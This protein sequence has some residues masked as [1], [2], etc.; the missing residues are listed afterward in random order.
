MASSTDALSHLRCVLH[1]RIRP[2]TLLEC[3]SDGAHIICEE[4]YRRR[5]DPKAKAC[6]EC[7]DAFPKK[8]KRARLAENF[9]ADLRMGWNCE[10]TT[11][12]C[13]FVVNDTDLCVG[14]VI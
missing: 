6:P 9:I 7:G 12:G 3:G 13:D 8:P 10:N 1:K 2:S 14:Y 4:C 5:L 11:H